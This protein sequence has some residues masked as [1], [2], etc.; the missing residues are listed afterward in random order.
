MLIYGS[1]LLFIEPMKHLNFMRSA[2]VLKREFHLTEFSSK[3]VSLGFM[4][5]TQSLHG[6]FG[7][8]NCTGVYLND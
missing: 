7:N 5:K 6:V 1:C 8:S 4:A 3:L 2:G